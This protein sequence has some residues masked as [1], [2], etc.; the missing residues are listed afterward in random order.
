MKNK[1]LVFVLLFCLFPLT[2]IKAQE[3]ANVHET[4][5]KSKILNQKRPILIYTPQDYNDNTLTSYDVIYVFDSQNREEFDLVHSAIGFLNF[6]KKF[7]IVG[8]CSPYYQETD[9]SRPNDYLP[10]PVNVSFYQLT[11]NPNSDNFSKYLTDEVFPFINSKYRT[12]NNNYAIGHSL[13]AS[14]V[15][16]KFI[17]S[18]DV[19]RGYIAISPNFAYDDYR[20]ANE[21]SKFDINSLKENKFLY[22]SQSDEYKT[23]PEQWNIGYEK[24]KDNISQKQDSGKLTLINKEFPEENHW[25][26]YL[27][28][29]TF[30]LKNLNTFIQNNPEKPNGEFHTITINV[31]TLNKDDEVYIVGN[32]ESL[33]NWNPS[34]IKMNYISDFQRTITLK[35]QF[36]LEFKITRGDWNSEGATNENDGDNILISKPFK[37]NV[38]N[39]KVIQWF[40]K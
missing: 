31:K 23:M 16:D 15:L 4:T 26:V 7:I 14:F 17:N 20:L 40:D 35:V 3:I 36:P 29:L 22:T 28:S 25:G 30:G 6:S 27:P 39:L 32:Q 8:I 33:G 38:I 12:T 10:K 37:S 1:I 18:T 5:I 11:K 2:K 34:K 13:S 21:F 19:F 24:Y 9:Y